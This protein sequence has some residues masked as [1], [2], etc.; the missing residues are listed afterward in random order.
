MTTN[1]NFGSFHQRHVITEWRKQE[2]HTNKLAMSHTTALCTHAAI[3]VFITSDDVICPLVRSMGLL[4]LPLGGATAVLLTL[5]TPLEFAMTTILLSPASARVKSSPS[6][7][8]IWLA[9]WASDRTVDD[10]VVTIIFVM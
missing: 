6:E 4:T 1:P 7:V 10:G 3:S 9:L 5:E 8:A 2:A